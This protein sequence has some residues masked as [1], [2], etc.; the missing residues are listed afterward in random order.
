MDE[1]G[2]KSAY[3]LD[4]NLYGRTIAQLGG[5]LYQPSLVNEFPAA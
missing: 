2:S 1:T 3:R 5:F 4:S